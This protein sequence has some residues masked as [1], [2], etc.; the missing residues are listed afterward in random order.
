MAA[1]AR[2]S[3]TTAK[4]PTAILVRIFSPN[5]SHG[6]LNLSCILL[7]RNPWL[8]LLTRAAPNRYHCQ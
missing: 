4:T 8:I 3:K 2:P 5:Y 7:F 6:P 1:G